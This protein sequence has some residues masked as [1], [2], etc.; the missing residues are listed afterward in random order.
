MRAA[1]FA[2]LRPDSLEE[3]FEALAQF[4][5]EA[6]LL[7]G[8]QSLMPAMALRMARPGVLVDISRLAALRGIALEEG[9]LVLGAGTTYAEALRAPLVATHTPLLVEAIP[10]IAHEAVRS[11]GTLGGSLANADPASEMPAC[12]LALGAQVV[13]RSAEGERAVSMEEFALGTYTTAIEPG[14]IL[15]AI[16]IPLPESPRRS[17]FREIARRSGDYAMAGAALVSDEAGEARFVL[18]AVSDRPILVPGAPDVDAVLAAIDAE[19]E[20]FPDNHVGISTKRHL[21]G[22]LARD[23]LSRSAPKEAA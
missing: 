5:D 21:A 8:G 22:V 11:R 9:A 12:M 20:F 19:V 2:Y 15:A 6:Q 3:A 1:P 18:F 17:R 16:R 7:A 23:L 4:G 14:E 10:H 13:L